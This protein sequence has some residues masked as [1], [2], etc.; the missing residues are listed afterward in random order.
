MVPRTSD[1]VVQMPGIRLLQRGINAR[2]A[3]EVFLIVP[4]GDIQVWNGSVFQICG[5]GMLLPK[6][7]VWMLNEVVPRR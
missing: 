2:R 6:I 3:D 5:H 7:V 4:A 1:E